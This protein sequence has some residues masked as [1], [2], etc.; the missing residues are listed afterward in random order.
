MRDPVTVLPEDIEYLCHIH[1]CCSQD[2][3]MTKKL[4]CCGTS[5][6]VHPEVFSPIPGVRSTY[7]NAFEE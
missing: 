4:G 5:S 1:L 2:H 7:A 6:G 3:S